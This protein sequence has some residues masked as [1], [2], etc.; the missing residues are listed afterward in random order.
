MATCRLLITFADSLNSDQVRSVF[1]L[2]DI[3]MVFLEDFFYERKLIEKLQACKLPALQR[4][5]KFGTC[6]VN[7]GRSITNL[8]GSNFTMLNRP[9]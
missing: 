6:T 7:F 1:K 9:S 4:G 3:L 8:E 5:D 2:F